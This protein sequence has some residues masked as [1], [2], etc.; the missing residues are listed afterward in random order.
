M[1]KVM[2]AALALIVVCATGTAPVLSGA[3]PADEV[4]QAIR[5][6]ELARLKTLIRTKSEANVKDEAGDTPL[7]HAAAIGSLDAVKLL[8]DAGADVN[9]RNTFEST[10]LIWAATDIA[11]VRYLL[12][13]GADV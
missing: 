7:M 1:S 4:Y 2:A 13:K 5:A 6:N 3:G 9:G 11:K 8:V 10:P 12:D